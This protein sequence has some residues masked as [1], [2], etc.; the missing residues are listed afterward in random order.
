MQQ[1][2]DTNTIN[3]KLNTI[4]SASIRQGR[5]EVKKQK[6]KFFTYVKP[7]KFPSSNLFFFVQEKSETLSSLFT[8]HKTFIGDV[9]AET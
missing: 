6:V 7:L 4:T 9:D 2:V 1:R 8:S 3:S 5:D